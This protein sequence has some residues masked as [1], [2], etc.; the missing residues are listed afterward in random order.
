MKNKIK[1]ALVGVVVTLVIYFLGLLI[2]LDPFRF[3]FS[4]PIIFGILREIYM[5]I[6][7]RT[8]FSIYNI[9]AATWGGWMIL[10]LI[11][12]FADK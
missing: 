3:A 5:L 6:I 12:Q 7:N 10:A 8:R 1:Q 2:G 4:S 9:I 11:Y